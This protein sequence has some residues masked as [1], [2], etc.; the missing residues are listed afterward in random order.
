MLYNLAN[1]LLQRAQAS[2][3]LAIF[4]EAVE[5]YQRCLRQEE[6][7]LELQQNARHNLELTKLLWLQARLARA[8][9]PDEKEPGQEQNP[10]QPK[11]PEKSPSEEKIEQG[12]NPSTG[13]KPKQIPEKKSKLEKK[14]GDDKAIPTDEPSAG[15]GNPPPPPDDAKQ[16]PLSAEN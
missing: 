6:T 8:S 3:D 14:Q 15:R 2:S 16:P 12:G 9:Q 5:T 1:C 10:E 11:P 13:G 4:R 7:P